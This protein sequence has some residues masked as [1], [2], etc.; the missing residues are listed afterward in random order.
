[1]WRPIT[2]AKLSIFKTDFVLIFFIFI[3]LCIIVNM[4]MKSLNNKYK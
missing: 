3:Y 1:M 4:H 2:L